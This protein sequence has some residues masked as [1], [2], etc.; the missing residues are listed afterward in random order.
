MFSHGSS[1]SVSCPS[2]PLSVFWAVPLTP[3]GY[4]TLRTDCSLV[5]HTLDS[6]VE[7]LVVRYR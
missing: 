3:R 7:E 4:S 2:S 5:T 6:V 1:D